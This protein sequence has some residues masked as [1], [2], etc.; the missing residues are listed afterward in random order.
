MKSG[1]IYP[2]ID[3]IIEK[4]KYFNLVEFFKFIARKFTSNNSDENIKEVNRIGTDV[5]IIIKWFFL[6]LIWKFHVSNSLITISI[7]Y[8]IVSNVYTYFYYHVW[9]DNALKTDNFTKARVKRRFMHLI[10]ALSFSV[11]CF[12]Y[13]YQIPYCNDIDWGVKNSSSL[14]SIMFSFSN[15]LA[16]NY[17]DIKPLSDI[18][19]AICNIQ[20]LITFL[21][22]TIILSRSVPQTDSAV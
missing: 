10:L 8:L 2:F 22:A 7:W 13:L 3:L 11:L 6:F 21:F 9:D 14:Y 5:F 18:G 4:T 17:S 19:N 16:S 1:I 15:S 20:I 12:A